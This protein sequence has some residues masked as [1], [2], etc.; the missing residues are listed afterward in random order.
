M[1][2]SVPNLAG[3]TSSISKAAQPGHGL[4]QVRGFVSI[5]S[6]LQDVTQTLARAGE[7]LPLD[8]LVVF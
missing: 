6:T 4:L 8:S 2:L 5:L 7:L 3:K 1:V